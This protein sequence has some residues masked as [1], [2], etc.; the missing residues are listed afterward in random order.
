MLGIEHRDWFI[1]PLL[2]STP[3]M[4]FSLDRKG[5]RY[6]ASDS[7]ILIFT[8]SYR[9]AL[10]ITTPTPSLVKTILR[11]GDFAVLHEVTKMAFVVDIT[12]FDES[13]NFDFEKSRKSSPDYTL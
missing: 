9:S 1:L 8:R 11:L 6:S 10:L 4:H 5:N 13:P 7:D 12:F 2:L 3:T